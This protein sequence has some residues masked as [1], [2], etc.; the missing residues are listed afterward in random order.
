[1]SGHTLAVLRPQWPRRLSSWPIPDQV[2]ITTRWSSLDRAKSSTADVSWPAKLVV[3]AVGQ[4]H[5]RGH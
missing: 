4:A 5:L 2:S 1:M 3:V